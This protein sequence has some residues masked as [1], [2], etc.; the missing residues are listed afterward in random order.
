[1]LK[2]SHIV[3]KPFTTHSSYLGI[4]PNTKRTDKNFP[5]VIS[6][7]DYETDPPP[8][9]PPRIIRPSALEYKRFEYKSKA[10]GLIFKSG[11]APA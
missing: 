9:P 3:I 5:P 7:A 2:S 10:Q 11:Y 8:P 6:P 4:I 1:M